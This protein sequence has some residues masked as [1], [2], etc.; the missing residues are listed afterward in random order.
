MSTARIRSGY[1][2]KGG[3]LEGRDIFVLD[4]AFIVQD[5][6]WLG[7]PIKTR[8]QVSRCLFGWDGVN[9]PDAC[10][11]HMSIGVHPG[12]WVWYLKLLPW[13]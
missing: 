12:W 11:I 3:Y 10:L 13:G 9:F 4:H 5:V 1:F 7:S 2:G 6:N 8:V